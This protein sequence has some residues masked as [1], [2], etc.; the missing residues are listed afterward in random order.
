MGRPTEWDSNIRYPRCFKFQTP[1]IFQ[2]S[3][4]QLGRSSENDI[5]HHASQI[6]HTVT[7]IWHRESGL[8]S[9]VSSL[10]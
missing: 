2:D 8:R 5:L 10:L 6:P 4:R 7:G 1:T 9:A 3:L